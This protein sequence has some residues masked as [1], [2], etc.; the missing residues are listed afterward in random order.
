MLNEQIIR[1]IVRDELA[2]F[3]QRNLA[4]RTYRISDTP[5][6]KISLTTKGTTTEQFLSTTTGGTFTD[7]TVVN[8]GTSAGT[9]IGGATNQK[10]GFFN[11]SPVVQQAA[12]VPPSGGATVDSQ[13]RTAVDSI[14]TEL[15]NLGLTG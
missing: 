9:K 1:N 10:I 14:I 3:K 4:F 13:A 11:H 15:Q 8:F 7:G 5:V 12:I 2:K 6:D